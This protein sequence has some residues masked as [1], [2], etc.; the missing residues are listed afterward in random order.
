[1]TEYLNLPTGEQQ[2]RIA[3]ALEAMAKTR[4]QDD[5][6]NSPGSKYI[7]AGD[8]DAGFYGFVQPKEFGE[9]VGNAT[10]KTAMSG[11]NL[12]LAIGLAQGTPINVDTPWMKFSSKGKVLFVPVKPLRHSLSWDSIYKQGAVYGDNTIGVAPP[13][14]R[15]GSR[16]SANGN[17]NSLSIQKGSENKG[18]LRENAVIAAVGD[19]IVIRGF[20][21]STNN[22]EFVVKSI[23]D[24]EIFVNGTLATETG[25][26][27]VKV[28]RKGQEVT[29]N[30][31]VSIGGQTYRVRL[32]KGGDHDP[33]QSFTDIDR[34]FVGSNSEWNNLILPTHVHARLQNWTYKHYAGQTEYWGINLTDGDLMT[35]S[36]LG[37]GSFTWVQETSDEESYRRVYRGYNGV[38][39]GAADYSWSAVWGYGWRPVLEL[40]S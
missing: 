29:Q 23:T 25:N 13:F 39:L 3:T 6:T 17:S 16:I 22:G 24:D 31:K 12:A 21:T 8:K 36:T 26:S 15:S 38:S 28:Y 33:L 40:Q 27:D 18:W 20:K 7:I 30:R 34:D 1:M 35:L 4:P 9:I 10:D 37:N 19:T 14:S 2:E 5:Y 11:D 32:L